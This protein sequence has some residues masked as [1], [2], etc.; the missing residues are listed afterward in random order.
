MKAIKILIVVILLQ[1]LSNH[2]YA[3]DDFKLSLVVSEIERSK[4]SHTT[5]YSIAIMDGILAY[6]S[7]SSGYMAQDPV[8]IKCKIS[9]E[10]IDSIILLIKELDLLKSDSTI[11][12]KNVVGNYFTCELL[13]VNGSEKYTIII[14]GAEKHFDNEELVSNVKKLF[15]ELKSRA[16]NCNE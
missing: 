16:F 10:D 2:S 14:N 9:G 4:D 12:E 3:G 1:F 5:E 8:F 6:A 15:N 13:I 7:E 11:N